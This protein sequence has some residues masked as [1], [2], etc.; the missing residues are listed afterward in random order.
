V[1]RLE[2]SRYRVIIPPILQDLSGRIITIDT[3]HGAGNGEQA[4]ITARTTAIQVRLK[5]TRPSSEQFGGAG[6]SGI[7]ARLTA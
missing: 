5:E 1:K 6:A 2:H 7:P 4:G 3:S